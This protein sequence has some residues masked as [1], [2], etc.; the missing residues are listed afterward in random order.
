LQGQQSEVLHYDYL[1]FGSPTSNVS[2]YIYN[3]SKE[4]REVKNKPYIIDTWKLNGM[5]NNVDVYRLEFSVKKMAKNAVDED[6][7]TFI[8]MN[9]LQMIEKENYIKIVKYL[10]QKHFKFTKKKDRQKRKELNKCPT[11]QFFKFDYLNI[12]LERISEKKTSNRMDKVFLKKLESLKSD[13]GETKLYFADE[14][15]LISNYFQRTRGLG[16]YK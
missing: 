8:K 11:I 13:F 6:E 14:I 16:Y 10:I 1:K 2:T 4:L 3:K 7:G 15:D 9:D 12:C 5:N